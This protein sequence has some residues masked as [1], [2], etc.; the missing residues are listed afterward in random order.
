MNDEELLVEQCALLKAINPTLRCFV[1]RNLVKAL[2]WYSSV[3]EKITDPNFSGWFLRNKA[4]GAFPNGSFHVSQCDDNFDPPRCS[5]LYHD[6]DQTPGFPHGDGSC[7]GP[8]D[9]GGP[10]IPCGEYLW[11]HRNSSLRS[12]IINDFLLG[13]TGLGNENISGFYLDDNWHNSTQPDDPSWQPPEGFCDHGPIGGP[14]E[15]NFWCTADM[16][17]TQADTT[18]ITDGWKETMDLVAQTLVGAGSWAWAFFAGW[19]LPSSSATCTQELETI[20]SQG[21]AWEGYG[22]ATMVQWT[23]NNA[24]SGKPR[25]APLPRVDLD[26][27]LFLTVRGPW[28]WLGYSWVGCSV[29]YEFPPALLADV[30]EPL[31]TCTQTTPGVFSRTWTKATSTVDCNAMSGAVTML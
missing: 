31:D 19:Q 9:C 4:G 18:A 15:E 6:L 23:L 3:R 12:W 26:I 22:Q 29:P 11:D 30:G 16:G 17:L 20:C 27:A 28:W 2:P 13:A 25:T 10:D 14:S 24:S 1:Y 5:T 7:P 21:T 8:C